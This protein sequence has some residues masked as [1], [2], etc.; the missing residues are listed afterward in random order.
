[1]AGIGG[2]SCD[3]V[4]G[5]A[6]GLKQRVEVWQ[7]P[8]IDGY[9]AHKVGQGDAEFSFLGIKYDTAANVQSWV[10]A[11]EALQGTVVSIVDDWG[12]TFTPCL[13]V[14]VG[15]PRRMAA[16]R[17]GSSYTCRGEIEV[18]GVVVTQ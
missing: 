18:L 15:R 1:M 16:V 9:G 6:R 7:L 10:A 12:V 13:I 17:P 11:I 5:N 2:V 4:K 8:G 3:M 14:S